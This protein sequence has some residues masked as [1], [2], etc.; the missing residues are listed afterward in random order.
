M[1]NLERLRKAMAD[2]GI[3]ALLVSEMNNVRWCSGFSGSFGYVVLSQSAGTF[4]SDGRYTQQAHAE[5]QGLHVET[6]SSPANP[7]EL[8]A[9]AIRRTG[10]PKVAVEGASV[11]Y[12]T[13]QAWGKKFAPVELESA[14]D[15]FSPLRMLKSPE[16]VDAIQRACRITDAC[17]DHVCRMVQPGVTEYDIGLDLEFFIRRSGA[18]IA[19]APGIVSGPR[20][21]LPHGRATERT[22]EP[23]DFL[24]L[25][26][27]AKVDG[28]VSDMTRTVVVGKP[29]ERHRQIYDLVL[30]AETAC[31][32]ALKVG[33]N[34][35][36]I[37]QL[38]VDILNKADLAKYFIHGLGHGI[39]RE[40]HD[41]GRLSLNVD[42][43]IEAGQVW[44]IEPGVYIEGF[45][46]VRIEDDVLVTP[47]GP[48]I[49]THS[50]RELLEL[51]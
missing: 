9:E 42:Q 33:E 37:V 1:T 35:N 15:L 45:G 19:F 8:V 39:G 34:G 32:S 46:G 36:R 30:E 43:P 10:Q 17:F 20:S 2:R 28:Y 22:L 16:E 40:V 3:G 31:C 24:T 48:R 27:G 44:T 11:T 6:C 7:I 12:D 18:E 50:P 51:G 4:V 29:S 25:D 47:E 49:L 23:G 21:A 38:A 13:W 14:G 5:V 41:H 26:F